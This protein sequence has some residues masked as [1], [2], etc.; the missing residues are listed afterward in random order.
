M[1]FFNKKSPEEKAAEHLEKLRR[2][3][4][5]RAFGGALLTPAGELSLADICV[6]RLAPDEQNLIVECRRKQLVIPYANLRGMTT[7]SEA[8]IARG[9]SSISAAPAFSLSR[10]DFLVPGIA[11]RLGRLQSIHARE[12]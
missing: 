5:D 10:S 12:I 3:E 7:S 2:T 6:M 9:E 8:E 11:T 1:F 4:G